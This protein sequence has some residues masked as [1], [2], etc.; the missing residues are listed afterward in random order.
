MRRKIDFDLF[1]TARFNGEP[2]DADKEKK[3]C[4]L[5]TVVQ[6]Q[7]YRGKYLLL[8]NASIGKS[9]NIESL[10]LHLIAHNRVFC[11]FNL[12]KLNVESLKKL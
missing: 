11:Y 6:R 8:G 10:K 4:P 7:G 12:N 5:A 9:S 2:I 1:S 3:L